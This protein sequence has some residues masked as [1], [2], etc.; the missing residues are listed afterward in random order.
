MHPHRRKLDV[1]QL[2]TV[3]NIVPLTTT[4]DYF[5]LAEKPPERIDISA[6]PE[7]IGKTLLTAINRCRLAVDQPNEQADVVAIELGL[8]NWKE[9]LQKS[10]YC[11]VIELQND[12]S[13]LVINVCARARGGIDFIGQEYVVDQKNTKEIGE[14]VKQALAGYRRK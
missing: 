12:P 11:S 4:K 7:D 2:G 5:V 10:S 6:D 14:R 8:K 13:R 1:Y 9:L 3:L